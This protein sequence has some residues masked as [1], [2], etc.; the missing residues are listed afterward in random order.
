MIEEL[1]LPV[2]ECPKTES[3]RLTQVEYDQWVNENLRTLRDAA[4]RQR[5][6][7]QISRTPVAVAF[8]IR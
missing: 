3:S 6:D 1:D 2:C 5:L 7:S 4:Q 8:R